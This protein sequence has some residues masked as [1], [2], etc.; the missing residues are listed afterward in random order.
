MKRNILNHNLKSFFYTFLYVA[1]P[2]I[3]M[4]ISTTYNVVMLHN[5]YDVTFMSVMYCP[6]VQIHYLGHLD[7]DVCKNHIIEHTRPK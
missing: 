4:Q 1:F 7:N 3:M 5:M 6:F 2:K